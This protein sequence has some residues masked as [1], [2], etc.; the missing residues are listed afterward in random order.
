MGL[1]VR[2]VK[3]VKG[4]TLDVE[5]QIGNELGDEA[6]QKGVAEFCKA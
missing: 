2:I 1:S 5:W 4:F 6:Y 3:R